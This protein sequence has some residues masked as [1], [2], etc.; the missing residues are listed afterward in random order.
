MKNILSNEEFEFCFILIKPRTNFCNNKMLPFL[1]KNVKLK[2]RKLFT[3]IYSI[4]N[5]TLSFN[6]NVFS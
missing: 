2:I 5:K 4:E 1:T 6:K 3:E